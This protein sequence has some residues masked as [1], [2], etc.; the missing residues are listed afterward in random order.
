MRLSIALL[1]GLAACATPEPGHDVRGVYRGPASTQGAVTIDHEAIPGV[2]DAMTMDF[3]F[4]DTAG[5]G[6]LRPGD[7]IRFRLTMPDG[8]AFRVDGL[9]R[10]PDTTQLTLAPA[11]HDAPAMPEAAADT[12]ATDPATAD[13]AAAAR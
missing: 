11:M 10:L 12:A 4:T 13:S 5:L 9:E 8:G 1:F 7:K 6:A 2:M 3:A